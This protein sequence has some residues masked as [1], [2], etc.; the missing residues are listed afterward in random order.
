MEKKIHVMASKRY[1]LYT[2]VTQKR[3]LNRTVQKGNEGVFHLK[4]T[5][6]IKKEVFQLLKKIKPKIMHSQYE[7]E[8]IINHTVVF[9]WEQNKNLCK[10]KLYHEGLDLEV[11]LK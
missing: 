9:F 8:I 10:I 5:L 11:Y 2:F 3:Q 6:N 7:L 4:L 1:Y